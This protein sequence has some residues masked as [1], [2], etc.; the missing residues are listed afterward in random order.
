MLIGL[1]LTGH[2]RCSSAVL[3]TG[4]WNRVLVV[5]GAPSHCG[6]CLYTASALCTGEGLLET[7][8]SIR[9]QVEVADTGPGEIRAFSL[10]QC[11]SGLNAIA[12]QRGSPCFVFHVLLLPGAAGHGETNNVPPEMKGRVEQDVKNNGNA[13]NQCTSLR[14]KTPRLYIWGSFV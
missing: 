3:D 2:P 9:G 10:P 12:G 1:V 5:L 4:I 8:P 14:L 11:R 13:D 6:S 7:T